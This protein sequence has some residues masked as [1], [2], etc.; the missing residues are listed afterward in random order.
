MNTLLTAILILTAA[1]ILDYKHGES[2]DLKKKEE[3][4]GHNKTVKSITMEKHKLDLKSNFKP[5]STQKPYIWI[6]IDNETNKTV[7]TNKI[8]TK[9]NNPKYM[10]LCVKSIHRFNDQHFNIRVL[11][12]GNITFFVQDLPFSWND[13]KINQNLKVDYIKYYLLYKYGGIW[14][15]PSVLAFKSFDGL[16]LKLKHKNFIT[17]GCQKT[18]ILCNGSGNNETINSDIL[19]ANKN[20]QIAQQAMEFTKHAIENPINNSTFNTESNKIL[21]NILSKFHVDHYKFSTEYDGS[22]D[23]KGKV[24]TLENLVSNNYT[25]FQNPDKVTFIQL[26]PNNIHLYRKYAWVEQMNKEQLFNSN[27][28]ISKLFR[29]SFGKNQQFFHNDN[30]T[31]FHIQPNN[32]KEF[33]NTLHQ[34]SELL[35]NPYILVHKE[36]HRNT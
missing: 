11:R 28:W 12:P 15:T 1:I 16:F 5:D 20:T 21:A 6:F 36:P 34:S 27:M 2:G 18:T 10:D 4:I 33:H 26:Y 14:V 29:H 3:F 7:K 8:K 30:H 19:L 9:K 31:S 23:F 32:N 17:F 22:R 24:I 25:L 35:F 13:P